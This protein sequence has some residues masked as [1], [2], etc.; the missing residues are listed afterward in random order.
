MILTRVRAL[1]LAC[2][3][4]CAP[5]LA[6]AQTQP[7]P[8]AKQGTSNI[9]RDT[10]PTSI[11]IAPAGGAYGAG[12]VVA[13]DDG[14]PI[15]CGAGCGIA[16]EATLQALNANITGLRTELA[17]PADSL[18][19]PTPV[20]STNTTLSLG[21]SA[22]T[23]SGDTTLVGATALQS[24]RLH[25]IYC[26]VLPTSGGVTV[27]FKS[28]ATTLRAVDFPSGGGVLQWL[29]RP[30]WHLKTA[31]N[32]ALVINFSTAG[33]YKCSFDYVKGA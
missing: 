3:F 20:A 22:I 30:Y 16:A 13:D 7:A 28:A 8:T 17:T 12:R 26:S 9:P 24:T 6:L 23:A 1:A 29:Y 32:E 4:A 21:Y 10:T 11:F 2:L 33:A 15:Q 27:T 25:A 18:P 5:A 19:P 14:L 31:N